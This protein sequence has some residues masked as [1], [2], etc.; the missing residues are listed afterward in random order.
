MPLDSRRFWGSKAL[1]YGPNDASV[2]SHR[3]LRKYFL[4]SIESLEIAG[5][6]YKGS[7]LE[8]CLPPFRFI[9]CVIP[10]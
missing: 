8:P 6:I 3:T 10:L 5:L 2:A 1:A 9:F 4:N 7:S